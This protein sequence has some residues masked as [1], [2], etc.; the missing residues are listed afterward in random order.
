LGEDEATRQVWPFAFTLTL[1][2]T[3]AGNRLTTV[4]DV[5]NP[6]HRPFDF[7]AALH[8]YLAVGDPAATVTGLGGLVAEDNADGEQLVAVPAD[9]VTAT[10]RRDLAVRDTT[11]PVTLTDPGLGS[12]I[13]TGEL[14]LTGDG[15]AD[16]VLWNPGPGRPLGDV[17]EDAGSEFV[18]IEAA[19]LSPVTLPAGATWTGRQTL[20][21]R[22]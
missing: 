3:A 10:G 7:T 13:L 18:C 4:L 16:R 5:H 19:R 21:A 17:P 20:T 2:A 6:G 14:T 22:P 12:V 8:G 9:P 15:F 11:A 1:T